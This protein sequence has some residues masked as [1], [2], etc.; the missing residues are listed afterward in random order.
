MEKDFIE[1]FSLTG[2]KHNTV[3][4]IYNF[5]QTKNKT[6]RD[7]SK[8]LKKYILRFPK[9]EIPNQECLV[10]IF[11]EGLVN[12]KLH[13]ALY[14]MKHNTLTTCIKDVI[15]LD[16]NVD[17]YKDER[18]TRLGNMGSL[19]SLDLRV[20]VIQTQPL[21]TTSQVPTI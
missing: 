21:V 13:A 3:T 10:S 16:N 4:H 20:I 18:P 17:K 8:R 11:V 14:P 5:K 15:E 6:V 12:K 9:K 19:R 2:I 7:C 1:S